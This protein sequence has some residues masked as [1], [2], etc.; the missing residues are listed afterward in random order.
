MINNDDFKQR[1]KNR[2]VDIMMKYPDLFTISRVII[3]DSKKFKA[4]DRHFVVHQTLSTR[5]GL[6]FV[7]NRIVNDAETFWFDF[8]TTIVPKII[9]NILHHYT[10]P[11]PLKNQMDDWNNMVKIEKL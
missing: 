3:D 5:I 11:Y 7:V 8:T 4:K 9:L 2:C 10:I 6:D 1:I